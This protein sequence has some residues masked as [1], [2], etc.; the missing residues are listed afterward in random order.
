MVHPVAGN[1]MP[2]SQGD[3]IGYPLLTFFG[4]QGTP[5]TFLFV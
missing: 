4:S 3:K 1:V 2:I 5:G